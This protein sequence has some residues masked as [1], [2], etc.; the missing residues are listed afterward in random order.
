MKKMYR[1]TKPV[2]AA[3]GTTAEEAF[4]DLLDAIEDDFNYALDGLDKLAQDGYPADA[5]QIAEQLQA[6]IN[7]SV[8]S[9]SAI[10]AE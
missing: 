5:K 9:I 6:S 1:N 2:T 10:L 8:S 4:N 3:E 7:A